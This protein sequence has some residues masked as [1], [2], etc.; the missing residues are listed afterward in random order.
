[1]EPHLTR[2]TRYSDHKILNGLIVH[3]G[4]SSW[5][6]SLLAKTNCAEETASCLRGYLL[7]FQKPRRIFTDNSK[8]F[9]EACQDLLFIVQKTTGSQK[10]LFD[11]EEQ[12][13][14]VQSGLP[15][16]WWTV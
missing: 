10:G 13:A 9:I 7:P 1:M 16:E 4:Y 12:P 2:R 11:E 8:E 5:L 6:Q 15:D 14:M 3:G